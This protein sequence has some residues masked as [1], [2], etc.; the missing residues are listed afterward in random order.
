MRQD[1]RD[2]LFLHWR[3]APGD[4]EALLPPGLHVDTFDGSAWIGITPFFMRKVRPRG[5]PAM[6]V[7]SSF[8]EVN[9]RTYVYDGHGRPGVWFLSLDTNSAV[10]VLGARMFASLPY[11][12]AAMRGRKHPDSRVE[13]S[14]RRRGTSKP[15]EFTYRPASMRD[16]PPVDSLEFFLIERYVLFSMRAGRLFYGRVHHHPYP[17]FNVDV[18]RWDPQLLRENGLTPPSGAF[19]HALYSPG[20]DVRVYPLKSV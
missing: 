5:V 17:L 12:L 7:V 2:L 15:S 4:I 8:M 11:F 6:P 20:V 1:W 3:I 13:Y 18:I 16:P 14:V 19:D 10:A 9:T